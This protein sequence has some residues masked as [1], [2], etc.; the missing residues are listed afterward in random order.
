MTP[1]RMHTSQD[2]LSRRTVVG[3]AVSEEVDADL[4]GG[5]VIQRSLQRR[6]FST[7]VSRHR[8]VARQVELLSAWKP[9]GRASCHELIL[10]KP[11]TQH[12]AFVVCSGFIRVGRRT[13]LYATLK[14]A[15]RPTGMPSP[16]N[17]KP[18]NC[19][20]NARERSASE[21]CG[22]DVHRRMATTLQKPWMVDH[23]CNSG[24][25]E[26]TRP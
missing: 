12:G 26:L 24:L 14:A 6:K 21:L 15:P 2:D 22:E 16:M 4:V 1:Q 8:A 9:A 23:L 13:R 10:Q 19:T 18:P 17:A 20:G 11:A 25:W 3:C 5:L 7:R